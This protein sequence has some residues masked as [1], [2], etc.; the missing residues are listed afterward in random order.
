M[1]R[2]IFGPNWLFYPGQIEILQP[3]NALDRAGST[4]RD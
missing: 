1:A 2:K 4:L 3:T